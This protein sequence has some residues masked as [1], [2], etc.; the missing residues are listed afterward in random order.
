MDDTFH[1]S[2]SIPSVSGEKIIIFPAASV[3]KGQWQTEILVHF[4]IVLNFQLPINLIQI[5]L[6]EFIR[7]IV[8]KT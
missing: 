6:E 8:S 5:I 3:I 4:L 2:Q 7:S 1:W